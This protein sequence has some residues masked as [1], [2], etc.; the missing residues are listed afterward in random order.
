MRWR[1]KANVNKTK[2]MIF[3]KGGRISRYL[4][5]M[6]PGC[7]IEIVKKF[8]YLGIVFTT[9][10]SFEHTLDALSGKALKALYKLSSV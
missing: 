4:H 2:V 9:A 5:F 8:T 1:L 6:Y 10:G 7:E 3:K